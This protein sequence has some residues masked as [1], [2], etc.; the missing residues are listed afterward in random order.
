ML[1]EAEVASKRRQSQREKEKGYDILEVMQFKL[2]IKDG[3]I[4]F[5]SE[6]KPQK[7]SE[8]TIK[9]KFGENY[10]S[11][12]ETFEEAL[13]TWKR[14]GSGLNERAFG[15]YEN[16]RPN[17]TAGQKGWGRKGKLDIWIVKNVVTL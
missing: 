17:T 2:K 5:G 7:T 11:V 13:Q 16:L 9:N 4:I 15:M 14:N 6:G 12:K 3:M 1:S 8:S 10:S